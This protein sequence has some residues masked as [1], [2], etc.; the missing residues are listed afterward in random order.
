MFFKCFK[1]IRITS[2]KQKEQEKF[3]IF[4]KLKEM[5]KMKKELSCNEISEEIKHKIEIRVK[6]LEEDIEKEISE[7]HLKEMMET[8]KQIGGAEDSISG[9]GR[10]HMWKLLKNK[11]PKI[12]NFSS[13]GE[14]R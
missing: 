11:F 8:L 5:K 2:N 10:K 3:K 14:K 9:E 1:K 6:E 13:S 12:F 7:E 4:D